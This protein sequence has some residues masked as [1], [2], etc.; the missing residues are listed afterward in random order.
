MCKWICKYARL[1][2]AYIT[3]YVEDTIVHTSQVRSIAIQGALLQD[4]ETKSTNA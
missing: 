3:G 4:P 1:C 2:L